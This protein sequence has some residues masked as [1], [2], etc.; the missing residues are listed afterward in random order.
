MVSRSI[1]LSGTGNE[2]SVIATPNPARVVL[3]V[4]NES[5]TTNLFVSDTSGFGF[6]LVEPGG[7]LMLLA[8]DGY[9][10]TKEWYAYWEDLGTANVIVMEQF[11]SNEV[12]RKLEAKGITSTAGLGLLIAGLMVI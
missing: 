6:F 9:D 11:L 5:T 12:M 2:L 3:G 10:L 4:R 8:V 1:A 7:T